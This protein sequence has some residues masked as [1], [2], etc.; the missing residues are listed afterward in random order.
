[1]S[2]LTNNT[3]EE[4][5]GYD[6]LMSRGK[7]WKLYQDLVSAIDP[8]VQVKDAY[9]GQHCIL[10]EAESG[11]GMSMV[12]HGGAGRYRLGPDQQ[13]ISL[14]DLASLATSWNFMEASVGVAAINAWH[15]TEE[16]ASANGM[17]IEEKGTNDGFDLYREICTGKK[18]VVVGHFP[19]IERLNEYCDLTILE[20]N[21]SEGDTPDPGCEYIIP[22]ADFL[23]STGLTLTNKTM[24]RLLELSR[25]CAG[26]ILVGPSVVPS[27][28][29]FDYGV[30]C[31]GGSVVADP[32]RAMHSLMSGLERGMFHNGVLKM[33]MERPGW[34]EEL[35]QKA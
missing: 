5:P 22:E 7:E 17:K 11:W 31:L 29:M 4:I 12:A 6:E 19:A 13:G 2:M 14:R 32:E 30:D 28:I 15:S 9:L 18:V 33:R 27:P 25:D 16:R 20:R 10:V 1:M 3:S 34:L 21:P 35:D 23:F 8:D 26:T 24:P